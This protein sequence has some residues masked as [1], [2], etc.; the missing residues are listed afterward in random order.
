MRL[1]FLAESG[2]NGLDGRQDEVEGELPVRPAGRRHDHVGKGRSGDGGDHVRCA[3]DQMTSLVEEVLEAG[4][5]YRGH[6][7]VEGLNDL[8]VGVN[9]D[10]VVAAAS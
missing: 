7:R 4:L 2:A 10:H 3:P 9:A 6:P 1:L 5:G 8:G